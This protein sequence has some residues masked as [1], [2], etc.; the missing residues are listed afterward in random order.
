MVE[1]LSSSEHETRLNGI[2]ESLQQILGSSR[3]R[4]AAQLQSLLE[5]IVQN[6][7]HGHDDQ[8]KER[9]IGICVFG[10][11]PDYET[12]DDPIVRSRVGQL[13]KRLKQYYESAESRGSSFRIVIP[14][15]TYKPTFVFLP[16]TQE[17]NHN[18]RDEELSHP[19]FDSDEADARTA[20]TDPSRK[21]FAGRG[22]RAWVIAAV[23]CCVLLLLGWTGYRKMHVSNLDLF[24]SPVLESSRPILICNGTTTA[25]RLS[26]S[27]WNRAEPA[28]EPGEME[29]PGIKRQVPA[30]TEGEVWASKD[31]EAIPD[32]FMTPGDLA[33]TLQVA[34]LLK[35]K[36]RS[37]G[38]R[39]G[40]NL[41]FVDLQSSPV[42]LVGAFNNAWTMDL[43]HNLPYFFDRG[44]HLREQGGQHRV[45][46]SH[47]SPDELAEED[48]AVVARI[49]NSKT[50]NPV[51]ILAGERNCGTEAAGE[52]A[53]D[54][55]QWSQLRGVSRD[56]LEKNN[57]EIVLHVSLD[58]C[59]PTSMSVEALQVW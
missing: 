3:F 30:L 50:G 42:I 56:A 25:F 29:Q 34:V 45:W 35:S 51:V 26:R 6:A 4:D 36:D 21:R 9:I 19:I 27:Y 49:L 20:T 14:T 53:T 15:G 31:L 58:H 22:W 46:V 47:R 7:V 55:G 12:A 43:N 16:E 38:L 41:P 11:K 52:F 40:S 18:R 5:F 59:R 54:R 17:A 1:G 28:A 32:G 39:T 37:Y 44:G 23:T 24:W 10:R 13:R 48:Y 57:L 8:L 33:T 2:E